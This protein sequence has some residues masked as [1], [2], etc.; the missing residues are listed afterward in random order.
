MHKQRRNYFLTGEM[1]QQKKRMYFS[2][3]RMGQQKFFF[4]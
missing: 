4:W 1:G 3:G 2:A